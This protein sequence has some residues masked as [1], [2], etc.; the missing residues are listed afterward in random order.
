[1]AAAVKWSNRKKLLIFF[2][3]I[4]V[5]LSGAE[6]NP[7]MNPFGAIF[8][9]LFFWRAVSGSRRR[10][11]LLRPRSVSHRGFQETT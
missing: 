10:N 8:R 1:M 7:R 5:C 3:Q 4:R 6:S 2:G 11:P 9:F